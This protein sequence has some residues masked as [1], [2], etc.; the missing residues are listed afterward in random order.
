MILLHLFL[1]FFKIGLFTIGG[2]YAM[3]PLI[4]EEVLQEPLAELHGPDRLY[5]GERIH[6]RA[7]CGEYRNVY[8]CGDG[9]DFGSGLRDGRCRAAVLSH[10]PAGGKVVLVHAGKPLCPGGAVWSAARRSGVDRGGGI[11]RL[12]D[13]LLSRRKF[14]CGQLDWCLHFCIGAGTVA[15][16]KAAPD[17]VDPILSRTGDCI[18]YHTGAI[19]RLNNRKRPSRSS[20][21]IRR[22]GF[23]VKKM[24][25]TFEKIR[26]FVQK[27]RWKV[28]IYIKKQ[29]SQGKTT[30]YL[31]K[32][33]I[34][35]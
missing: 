13:Q 7:V 6:A 17:P 14:H 23:F 1:T 32:H 19:H 28:C 8:R 33:Y 22:D 30:N 25:K 31:D 26:A 2:G 24:G 34:S 18:L 21:W 3:I 29:K 4:Q 12:Y 10:H 35:L 15:L 11:F 16:E 27:S 9:G 5:C 20:V